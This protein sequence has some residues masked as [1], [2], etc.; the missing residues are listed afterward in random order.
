MFARWSLPMLLSLS[1]LSTLGSCART[2]ATAELSNDGDARAPDQP[3]A[4]ELAVAAGPDD[5]RRAALVEQLRAQGPAALDSLIAEYRQ[6]PD[7]AANDDAAWRALIDEVAQQ[8][9]AHYGG[10]FW[11]RDLSEAQAAAASSGKPILSLR[12]LGELTS[13]YSCANSRLFRTLLYADP[14]LAA[15]LEYNFVLHWSS[16]RPVPKLEIDFGDGRKI[17]RT[18]TGNSA[19]FVLDERGRTIDV[20][21][22]LLSATSFQAA[23]TDSLEL[24]RELAEVRHDGRWRKQLARHHERRFEESSARLTDSLAQIRGLPQDPLS[25]RDWLTRSPN[26]SGERVPAIEA[27]PMAIGKS[28]IEAPI[29]ERAP[30]SLGGRSAP[31]AR[32]AGQAW[33]APDELE[34]WMLGS[35]VAGDIALHPNSEAIIAGERPLDDL[36][37]AEQRET[38]ALALRQTLIRSIQADTGKNLFEM[39]ARVHHELAARARDDRPLEFAEVDGWIYAELFETP[40]SDPWLGL[41]DP[42]VYTGLVAGGVIAE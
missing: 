22:G 30:R 1:A 13:E 23:L 5:P 4:I 39:R 2:P 6:V 24:S 16:E 26:P 40:A 32:E 19:H 36:V 41:I 18:I 7:R 29:L 15:W 20:I 21:P 35:R 3:T 34:L 10:L 25:V 37:P 31:R 38:A 11:H 8:R 12:L 17:A 42:A 28:K 33:L 27:V 14:E 9:D